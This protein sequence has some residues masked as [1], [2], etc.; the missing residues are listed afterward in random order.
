MIAFAAL[1]ERLTLTPGRLA[2]IALMQRFFASE[3]DPDRGWG[4][5]SLTGE[6]SFA[7]AKAG[8]IRT[9]AEARTDPILFGLSY[10]FV[11]DLAETVSLMWPAQ[12]ALHPPSLTTVVETLQSTPTASENSAVPILS[13][14]RR[15]HDAILPTRPEREHRQPIRA[16]RQ[17]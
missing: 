9:L 14:K 4:L 13:H 7:A 8:L 11:G 1:I 15:C 3:T 17:Q 2:K 12:V 6:L 16:R 5:A 10:D